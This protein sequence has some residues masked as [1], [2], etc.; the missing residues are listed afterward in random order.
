MKSS[1]KLK[2]GEKE[3]EFVYGLSFLGKFYDDFG[4]NVSDIIEDYLANPHGMIPTLMYE[5]Y[6]HGLE[7]K[8]LT[9]NHTKWEFTDLLEECGGVSSDDSPAVEFIKNFI[10]SLQL[11]LPKTDEKKDEVKKK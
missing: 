1:I 11:N 10:D 6:K 5:S 9:L 3:L 8:G 4:K 7:R 2:F